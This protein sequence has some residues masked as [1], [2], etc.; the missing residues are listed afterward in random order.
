MNYRKMTNHLIK[1]RGKEVKNVAKTVEVI[2]WDEFLA[3]LG[4]TTPR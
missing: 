4:L 3:D 1:T 2:G